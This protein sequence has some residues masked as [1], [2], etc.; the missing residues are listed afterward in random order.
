MS[1]IITIYFPNARNEEAK[2]Q[3]A[4]SLSW[5]WWWNFNYC[6]DGHGGLCWICFLCSIAQ[7]FG[8]TP[9]PRWACCAF[10][11]SPHEATNRVIYRSSVRWWCA[12]LE[13]KRTSKSASPRSMWN[14][15][16]FCRKTRKALSKPIK[17][18]CEPSV[19]DGKNS[20]PAYVARFSR[21]ITSTQ[22]DAH[23]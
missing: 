13:L 9:K 23:V 8:V 10:S 17:L 1:I 11:N 18:T 15:F 20:T 12:K 21:F 5:W 6:S 2:Q 16:A 3:P 14:L 19:V 22:S 7:W 4:H